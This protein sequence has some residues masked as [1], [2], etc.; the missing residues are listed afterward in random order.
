M[1]QHL[2][3]EFEQRHQFLLDLSHDLRTP[4]TR[5]K[6]QFQFL[7]PSQEISA[8]QEDVDHMICMIQQY[9]EFTTHT[10]GDEEILNFRDILSTLQQKNLCVPSRDIYW[11]LGKEL[12]YSVKGNSADLQRC[13]Q[14]LLDNALKYAQNCI[15]I[16]LYSKGNTMILC[17]QDDGPGI[18]E[19]IKTKIFQPFFKGD[20]SRT[21]HNLGSTGL[22]LSITE[23]ILKRHEG[24]IYVVNPSCVGLCHNFTESLPGAHI[25]MTLPLYF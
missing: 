19:S 15:A 5:I 6:L 11:N 18:A 17:I 16:S 1:V 8:L 10:S 14:N 3:Q 24:S 25:H 7:P 23:R 20:K 13:V 21:A 2:Q 9:L 22:G 4:L 12:S